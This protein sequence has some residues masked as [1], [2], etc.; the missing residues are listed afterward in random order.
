MIQCE[1]CD[2]KTKLSAADAYE[3]G[4]E[5]PPFSK[6]TWCPLCARYRRQS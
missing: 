5:V 6:M 1:S 3:I 4:W 2:H